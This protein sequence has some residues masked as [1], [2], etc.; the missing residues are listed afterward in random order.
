MKIIGYSLHLDKPTQIISIPEGANYLNI[1]NDGGG[2]KI[3]FKV[4][5]DSLNIQ[6]RKFLQVRSDVEITERPEDL[7]YLNTFMLIN[8]P[9]HIFEIIENYHYTLTR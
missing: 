5:S 4:Y 3:F 8:R 1:L 6:T 9:I 2:V 7:K